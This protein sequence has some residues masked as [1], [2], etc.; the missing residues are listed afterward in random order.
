[1]LAMT[2]QSC[3]E[4]EGSIK[5]VLDQLES[6]S[7]TLQDAQTKFDAK[8]DEIEKKKRKQHKLKQPKQQQLRHKILPQK[9]QT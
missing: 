1:M 7:K 2:K 9:K 8:A 4:I 3:S 6:F 5:L